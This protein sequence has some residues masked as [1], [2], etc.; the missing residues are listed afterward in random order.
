[1]R[2][3][4]RITMIFPGTASCRSEE[5]LTVLQ[6]DLFAIVGNP[7]RPG[8]LAASIHALHRIAQKVRDRLSRDMF[9]I[10]SNLELPPEDLD[11]DLDQEDSSSLER[12]PRDHD[13]R[14]RLSTLHE[15]LDQTV[16][17]LGAF[18]GLVADSMTR[19][20]GWRFLDMGRRLERALQLTVMLR[21]TLV[22]VNVPEAPLLEAILEIGDS[23][24]TYRRRYMSHMEAAPVLDLLLADEANPRSLVAQLAALAASIDRLPRNEQ[25]P[26]RSQAQRVILT[27]LTQL[28][29]ADI[30]QLARN[31]PSGYRPELETL[32]GR[33]E[34]DIP[35]L[36]D[37]LTQHYFTH[38]QPPRQFGQISEN[39]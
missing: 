10:L 23:A 16:I 21:S 12:G 5:R 1:M 26:G 22:S 33:L 20:Q 24:M 34:T 14:R 27:A 9:R 15:V 35:I 38:L 13:A 36:S 17:N 37:A 11:L 4:T 19:G 7:R 29:V 3:L 2:A 32:L 18:G 39:A 31:D 30:G 25:I 28:R 8:S 6:H